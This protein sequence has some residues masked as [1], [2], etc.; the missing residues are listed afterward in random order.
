MIFFLKRLFGF[1]L[2]ALYKLEIVGMENVP[3][4]GSAVLCANHIGG[5]DMFFMGCHLHRLV[6]YMA[7]EE[8]FKNPI[9]GFLIR[10]VGGFPVRR[11]R[12]DVEAIKTA[13]RV[14]AE[15][16]IIGIFPEGTRKKENK[17]IKPGAAMIAARAGVPIIPV[18]LEGNYK[19][20]S[21]VKVVF[22]K[23]FMLD[24]EKDRKYTSE[25]LAVFSQQIMDR[26]YALLEEH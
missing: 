3:R 23:P 13:F 14:L 26:V 22:G 19:L 10:W 25:E 12:A 5:M 11:G 8:L 20:F 9:L 1:I 18:A 7:K 4:K 17:K 6:H 2:G 21:K 24:A 15:G 16:H